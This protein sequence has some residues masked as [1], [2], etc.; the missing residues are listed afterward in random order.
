MPGGRVYV[1]KP[2]DLVLAV[3]RQPSKLSF[4]FLEAAFAVGM[5]GLT[6]EAAVAL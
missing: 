6:K 3:Q 4:W 2:P 5:A 1:V